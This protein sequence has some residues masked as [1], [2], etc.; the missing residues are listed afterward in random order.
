MAH[1]E[2]MDG[3]QQYPN[4]IFPPTYEVHDLQAH[5]QRLLDPKQRLFSGQGDIEV[6][7]H[8]END[9]GKETSVWLLLLSG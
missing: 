2:A 4:E 7:R 9:S 5:R 1:P 3:W 8:K 6:W